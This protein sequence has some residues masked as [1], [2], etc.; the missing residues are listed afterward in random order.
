MITLVRAVFSVLA[1]GMMNTVTAM[2][3][4]RGWKKRLQ[5]SPPP[6][7]MMVTSTS[8]VAQPATSSSIGCAP[9]LVFITRFCSEFDR[10]MPRATAS[11]STGAPKRTT[12]LPRLMGSGLKMGTS[13]RS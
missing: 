11:T 9:T 10:S 12:N 6:S 5:R 7:A 13:S 4:T 3:G 2:N 1:R 8:T